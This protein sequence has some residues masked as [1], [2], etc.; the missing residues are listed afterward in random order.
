MTTVCEARE[1][2]EGRSGQTTAGN[3]CFQFRNGL[4]LAGRIHPPGAA[5]GFQ[6]LNVNELASMES[7]ACGVTLGGGDAVREEEIRR[8]GAR[9]SGQE[10]FFRPHLLVLTAGVKGRSTYVCSERSWTGQAMAQVEA[11]LPLPDKQ[12]QGKRIH[13]VWQR[14]ARIGETKIRM[15]FA[16]EGSHSYQATAKS[17]RHR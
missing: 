16:H 9:A 2:G 10:T 15:A 17:I 3:T 4:L 5:S 7:A 12:S 11:V 13:S 6:A 8:H 14:I 1:R